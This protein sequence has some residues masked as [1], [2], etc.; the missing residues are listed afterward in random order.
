MKYRA[1][2]HYYNVDSK[3]KRV[4]GKRQVIEHIEA[5]N[6]VQAKA[7]AS[8]MYANTVSVHVAVV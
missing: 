4:G 5:P 3:G 6:S 7:R 1:M 8:G 2:I